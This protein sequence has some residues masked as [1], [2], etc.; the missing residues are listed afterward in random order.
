MFEA[1]LQQMI[2]KPYQGPVPEV[3]GLRPLSVK[4]DVYSKLSS[5]W[6]LC[7][8]A[9]QNL[10]LN[11]VLYEPNA[12]FK[13]IITVLV[14]ALRIFICKRSLLVHLF[15]LRN[16]QTTPDEENDTWSKSRFYRKPRCA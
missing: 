4:Q 8:P 10:A 12:V 1:V 5:R 16:K 14:A 6:H 13:A 9:E 2:Q 7:L 15:Q 11:Y 3:M